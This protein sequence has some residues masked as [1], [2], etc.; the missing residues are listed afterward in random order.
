[1][2]QTLRR[3][4]GLGA[5]LQNLNRFVDGSRYGTLP[6]TGQYCGCLADGLSSGILFVLKFSV[7][8]ENGFVSLVGEDLLGIDSV[9][10][11]DFPLLLLLDSLVV[12]TLLG[13]GGS[14]DLVF[15]CGFNCDL[16]N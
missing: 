4:W 15:D 3:L 10:L 6:R 5:G 7:W 9:L 8:T 16:K 12:S 13:D 2:E 1:M 11:V 14:F